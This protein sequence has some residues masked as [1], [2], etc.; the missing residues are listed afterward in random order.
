MMSEV[1]VGIA[2]RWDRV[3]D[4]EKWVLEALDKEIQRYLGEG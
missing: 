4:R 3:R 2:Y 1:L